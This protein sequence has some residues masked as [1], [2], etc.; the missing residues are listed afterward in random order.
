[1]LGFLLMA[2]GIHSTEDGALLGFDL[3]P[4]FPPPPTPGDNP[5]TEA[6]AELGRHL[7]FDT[8]LSSDGTF[9]CSSC[10]QPVHAF[11]D[12]RQRAIGVTGDIHPRN[13]MGLANVAYNASLN[14]ADPRLNRLEE[15]ME[16]PMFSIKPVEMGISG[17]EEEVLTRLLGEPRYGELFHEAFP[18]QRA[19]INLEN[20]ILAIASFERTLI[21]GSSPYDRYVY[22]DDRESLSDTARRGMRLFFSNE[23]ACSQCHSG[24]NFSGPVV[25]PGETPEPAFHNTALYDLDGAGSYPEGNQGV[26]EHTGIAED[27]GRFR[28][29]TLRNIALT[30][31]YM[32]DGSLPT[33]EAVIEHYAAAGR[34][35]QNPWKSSL[36]S[37]FELSAAESRDLVRFLESLTDRAFVEDPRFENPWDTP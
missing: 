33:L 18:E 29:P 9:S 5:L 3:P 16:I 17:H 2:S 37:G 4:G 8:R 14:W 34:A 25:L 11:T 6:K 27:M 1:M 21:S 24:F 7:F 22:W 36:V 13:T 28:A 26:I 20:V 15:Q 31:P 19:P 35:A 32:H 23:L 12:S 30:A 10:H